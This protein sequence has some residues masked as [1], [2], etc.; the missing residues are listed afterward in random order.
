MCDK[1]LM[2]IAQIVITSSQ[3]M[4]TGGCIEPVLE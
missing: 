1:L 4:N 2:V 3:V